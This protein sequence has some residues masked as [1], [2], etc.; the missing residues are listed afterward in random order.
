VG[1]LIGL[2]L[3]FALTLTAS[4]ILDFPIFIPAPLMLMAIG[5]CIL[6]GLIA[7]FVPANIASRMNP[8]TAIRS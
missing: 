2:L 6:V 3:V 1:G 8:V 4:A 7:G 5:I